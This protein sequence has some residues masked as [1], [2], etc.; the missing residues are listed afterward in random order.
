VGMAVAGRAGSS[1]ELGT[2]V[3]Q[4]WT[5]HPVLMAN[6]AR[7]VARAVGGGRFTLG[8]GV[9]HAPVV[10]GAFGLDY[11]HPGRHMLEYLSVLCP[12]LRGEPVDFDGADFH[13]RASVKTTASDDP[14]PVLVAALGPRMLGMAGRLAEGTITWMANRRA[15][16]DHVRPLITD[17]ASAAGRPAPRIVAGLPV[18]VCDDEREGREAAAR[19]FAMYGALPNYRRI[20]DIGGVDGPADAAIVGDEAAVEREIRALFDAGATDVWAAIFGVGDD[21]VA[22]R[23][24]A[25]DLARSLAAE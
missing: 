24:R 23:R 10:E 11:G 14:V 19:E 2:S 8:I 1:I 18:A 7:M 16:A 12:L 25:R 17:A 13:A 15:V 9:S 5:R 20:L 4:T 3:L 6:E 22:S 21:R